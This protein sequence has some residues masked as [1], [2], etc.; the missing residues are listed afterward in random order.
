MSSGSGLAAASWK[1]ARMVAIASFETVQ[2]FPRCTKYPFM[3]NE[4]QPCCAAKSP[5]LRKNRLAVMGVPSHGSSLKLAESLDAC[6]LE[7]SMS[8]T[9]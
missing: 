8:M 1:C 7:G 2:M 3:S 9:P 6:C 4:Y 5:M